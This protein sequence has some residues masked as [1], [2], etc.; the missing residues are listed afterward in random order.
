MNIFI[1]NATREKIKTKHGLTEREIIEAFSNRDGKALVDDREEHK[2][3]PRT[4][5]FV[6]ETNHGVKIKVAYVLYPDGLVHIKSAYKPSAKVI[7]LY[8]KLK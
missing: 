8:N 2:T 1:S 7:A 5:W 4:L 6:A 3:D